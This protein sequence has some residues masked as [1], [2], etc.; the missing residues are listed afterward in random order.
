MRKSHLIVIWLAVLFWGGALIFNGLTRL[1]GPDIVVYLDKEAKQPARLPLPETAV[2]S[3]DRAVLWWSVYNKALDTGVD[4]LSARVA[5]SD[6][7]ETVYG[8]LK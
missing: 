3:G 8:E 5:A 4:S 7:V 2:V 1:K 6:A